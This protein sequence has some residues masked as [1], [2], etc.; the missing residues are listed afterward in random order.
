MPLE[1][2]LICV[3]NS[4]EMRNGDYPA[5][6]RLEAVSDASRMVI[7]RKIASNPESTV[8]LL[9]MATAPQGT[10]EV[11]STPS[12]NKQKLDARLS[13]VMYIYMCP[14]LLLPHPPQPWR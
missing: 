7:A 10:I 6:T 4:R 14:S 9:T 11:R 12:K 13:Q 5:G 1:S 3:D 8:G 2:T